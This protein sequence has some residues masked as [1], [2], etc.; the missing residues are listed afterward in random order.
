MKKYFF[1]FPLQGKY[2]DQKM[3]KEYFKKKGKSNPLEINKKIGIA[4]SD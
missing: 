2:I 3:K 1:K 4:D